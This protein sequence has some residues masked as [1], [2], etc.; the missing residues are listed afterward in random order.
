MSK[1]KILSAILRNLNDT[2]KNWTAII[3]ACKTTI[4]MANSKDL[5]FFKIKT[6]KYKISYILY[7]P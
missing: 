3:Q 1:Q 4:F 6:N 5:P 7:L 2:A